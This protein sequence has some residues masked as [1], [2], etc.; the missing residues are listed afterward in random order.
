MVSQGSYCDSDGLPAFMQ[1]G[2][3][4]EDFD[5]EGEGGFSSPE[6]GKGVG[7][8]AEKPIPI[9]GSV[10]QE[11]LSSKVPEIE[12]L[13]HLESD[14]YESLGAKK[15]VQEKVRKSSLGDIPVVVSDEESSDENMFEDDFSTMER[16]TINRVATAAFA[17]NRSERS[18][19]IALRMK[20]IELQKYMER[21]GLSMAK[22]EKESI[23]GDANFNAGLTDSSR[24]V[25][26]RDEFGLP[27]FCNTTGDKVNATASK[28]FE[29]FP[30]RKEEIKKLRKEEKKENVGEG[31]SGVKD[32]QGKE[33]LSEDLAGEEMKVTNSK[34]W[35]QVVKNV[36]AADIRI[37][38]DYKPLPP[39]V[40]TISPPDEVLKQGNEKF[41]NYVIGTFTKG[42]VPFNKVQSFARAAWNNKGLILTS[43]KDSNTFL[44]KFSDE[45]QK[46]NVISRGTWYVA[47]CPMVVHAWG[48]KIGDGMATMIPL[49][50]KFERVPDCYWTKE[51]LSWLASP[52][53]VP[54][55]ADELTSKLEVLPFARMCVNYKVGDTLPT[56]LEVMNLDPISGEKSKQEVLVSYPSKPRLCTACHD[57]GHLVGACPKVTRCWVQK[58]KVAETKP[59]V[60]PPVVARNE[61]KVNND[62]PLS[63]LLLNLTPLSLLLNGQQSRVR[64][65][66]VIQILYLLQIALRPQSILSK[67]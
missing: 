14:V 54:L 25:T 2:L 24:F 63:T 27:I 56:K 28:V 60:D 46:N 10:L 18:E 20:M 21:N 47:N 52:I 16:R 7:V 8:Y 43:Q 36:P 35:S 9:V 57:L 22:F 30:Q 34:T 11:I 6:I 53:G 50:V 41:K 51:G 67:I 59:H 65:K 62:A 32:A 13:A 19:L 55:Y 23:L 66:L 3:I 26:G 44:F 48:T 12:P 29:E 4:D 58:T 37:S 42:T 39:G 33:K 5:A 64:K 1:D 15:I 45:I 49:W 17:I 40:T 38:F 31:T 61:Q